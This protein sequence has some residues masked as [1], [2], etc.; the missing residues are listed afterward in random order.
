MLS[1]RSHRSLPCASRQ[2][3]WPYQ[4]HL[5]VRARD[6]GRPMTEKPQYRPP[7]AP[8]STHCTGAFH[9][10]ST[11]DRCILTHDHFYFDE[12]L[13][14][15]FSC[16]Q[17]TMVTPVDPYGRHVAR[18]F[19]SGGGH[20]TFSARFQ[21]IS[22]AFF[23]ATPIDVMLK[24]VKIQLFGRQSEV[25]DAKKKDLLFRHFLKRIWK[26][27]P[28]KNW[29]GYWF[30]LQ[31]QCKH[32]KACNAPGVVTSLDRLPMLKVGMSL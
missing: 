22:N 10:K 14:I 19:F 29:H 9:D 18:I 6:S 4:L 15:G 28:A 1:A 32:I 24:L 16:A 21:H 2:P 7:I 3:R 23:H 8:D 27:R 13:C 17:K 11:N 12:N 25:D 30:K 20:G 31:H 5:D 26:K